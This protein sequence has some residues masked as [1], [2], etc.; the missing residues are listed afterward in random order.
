MKKILVLFLS[1]MLFSCAKQKPDYA[2]A[3]T[4]YK[5]GLSTAEVRRIFGEPDAELGVGQ[6]EFQW[7]YFPDHGKRVQH[8]RD[9]FEITF[10]ADSS[11]KISPV[12]ISV[13]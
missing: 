1:V 4:L 5:D 3:R 9:G 13:N 7:N 12:L 8:P 11:I 2:K 10:R 6:P